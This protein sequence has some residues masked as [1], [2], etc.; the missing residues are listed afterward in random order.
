MIPLGHVTATMT[1]GWGCRGEERKVVFYLTTYGYMA[2]D[3]SVKDHSV[4]DHSES[5]RGNPLPPLRLIFPNNIK[6]SFI[7]WH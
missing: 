4:K 7:Y 1:R 3:H 6:G 5:E 2:S